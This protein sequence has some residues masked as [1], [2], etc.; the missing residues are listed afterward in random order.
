MTA[1][2]RKNDPVGEPPPYKP[3]LTAGNLQP[4]PATFTDDER[5]RIGT[6]LETKAEKGYK[7]ALASIGYRATRAEAKALIMAD[8][9]LR[10]RYFAGYRLDQHSVLTHIGEIAHDPE[11]KDR[12]RA[13]TWAANALLGWSEKTQADVTHAGHVE[14]EDRSAHLD[15][16]AAVLN[17]VGAVANGGSVPQRAL[18]AAPDVLAEPPEG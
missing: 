9:E 18:P 12:L 13:N 1:P 2:R 7:K 11:H 10:E 17:A 5:E 15:A 8:D 6:F 3:R 16:V 4:A 14:V